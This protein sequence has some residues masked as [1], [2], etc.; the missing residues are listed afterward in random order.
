MTI[1][2]A[3]QQ[4]QVP[5]G[6]HFAEVTN[7]TNS[8]RDLWGSGSPEGV[9]V[10]NRGS[11]YRD[12]TNGIAYVKVTGTG[13]TGWSAVTTAATEVAANTFRGNPTAAAAAAQ[14]I[15]VA[16]ERILG[17]TLA[18]NLAALTPQEAR[19]VAR[20]AKHVITFAATIDWDLANGTYQEI[21]ATGNFTLNF[22]SNVVAGEKV[23]LYVLGSAT[24]MTLGAGFET[25]GGGAST[26]TL[27]GSKNHVEIFFDTTTTATISVCSD[28]AAPAAPV[29]ASF[30]NI[31]AMWDNGFMVGVPN[32]NAPF[33]VTR[34]SGGFGFW[35]AGWHYYLMGV[36]RLVPGAFPNW[37]GMASGA[38][39]T[40]ADLTLN[41]TNSVLASKGFD[42]VIRG[43]VGTV[44]EPSINNGI[45]SEFT[46]AV[47]PAQTVTNA[48]T[49]L[50]FDVSS[51]LDE[52]ASAGGWNATRNVFLVADMVAAAGAMG[53]F[54][55]S[56]ITVPTVDL[57]YLIA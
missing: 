54:E 49:S 50:T 47:T 6:G 7:G 30:T 39:F 20:R 2:L 37:N 53:M 10:A 41:I 43:I 12:I 22:P 26:L 25:C 4:I 46:T 44:T 42:I 28:I 17:R 3:P 29:T 31:G 5:T 19:L 34:D 15:A 32:F 13:N 1:F 33:K 38:T 9:V 55:I 56:E 21:T 40:S 18:G 36:M 24:T 27:A 51:I 35:N 11:S 14:N 16:S 8:F 57:A 52:I 45:L 23:D 48:T